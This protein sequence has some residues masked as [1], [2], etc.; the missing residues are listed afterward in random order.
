MPTKI[1]TNTVELR[2]FFVT[3]GVAAAHALS[4][5]A[6]L[7]GAE[8]VLKTTPL[9]ILVDSPESHRRC[10]YP[11]HNRRPCYNSLSYAGAA[12]KLVHVV[13]P[14]AATFVVNAFCLGG[15]NFHEWTLP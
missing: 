3:P 12:S 6:I 15:N 5:V 9:Y 8:S 10:F 11:N 14:G 2:H 1:A 4:G 7:A 13:D